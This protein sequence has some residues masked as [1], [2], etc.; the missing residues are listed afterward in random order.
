MIRAT[1]WPRALPD[2][3]QW[4]IEVAK[5]VLAWYF[6]RATYVEL[7]PYR[8]NDRPGPR[9]DP[10]SNVQQAAIT[11]AEVYF[12]LVL[13]SG[14][15]NTRAMRTL[16]DDAVYWGRSDPVVVDGWPN[17]DRSVSKE[18]TGW[19][20]SGRARGYVDLALGRGKRRGKH[21]RFVTQPL[22]VPPWRIS[23]QLREAVRCDEN[24]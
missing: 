3:N 20:L 7:A 11:E 24:A 2:R 1:L 16:T 9:P 18:L 17:V 4:D 12:D 14:A 15:W 22:V 10:N 19:G 8:V 6:L 13:D 23:K 5:S 21:V